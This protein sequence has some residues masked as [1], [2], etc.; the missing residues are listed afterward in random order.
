MKNM[1]LTTAFLAAAVGSTS[2]Q[3]DMTQMPP[4]GS[5]APYSLVLNRGCESQVY[6][7]TMYYN[8]VQDFGT[9]IPHPITGD[10]TAI[11]VSPDSIV[12][13]SVT[14]A[15]MGV[16]NVCNCVPVDK[17]GCIVF[18]GTPTTAGD[19]TVEVTALI[20]GSAFVS[21]VGNVPLSG[22]AQSFSLTL[23][24][25]SSTT[26]SQTADA[27]ATPSGDTLLAI[28]FNIN[29]PN[30]YSYQWVDCN[31]G[32]APIVGATNPWFAPSITGDYAVVVTDATCGG[33]GTSPC[34]SVV[35]SGIRNLAQEQPVQV[36]P[37]PTAGLVN[38]AF[39]QHLQNADLRVVSIT[40]QTLQQLNGLSGNL[41]EVDLNAYNTGIYFIEVMANNTVY[42]T[43][44]VKN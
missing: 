30:A 33:N 2:A 7:D 9:V 42:R 15:P 43:K 44:V 27:I 1:L 29:D 28:P 41:I 20:Y 8:F 34:R 37:N 22:N 31:N 12:I 38:L 10:P 4:N 18:S 16:N 21:G 11:L 3:C 6:G 39:G 13:A 14:G 32:N 24:V 23:S 36:Y 25:G 5:I 17:Q 40:G 35:I 19:Y 26:I